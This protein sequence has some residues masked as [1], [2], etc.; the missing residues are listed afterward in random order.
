MLSLLEK[1]QN[2]GLEVTCPEC[3]ADLLRIDFTEDITGMVAMC[4][5]EEC[6]ELVEEVIA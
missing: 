5:C 6:G 3:G 1:W 4:E 2:K